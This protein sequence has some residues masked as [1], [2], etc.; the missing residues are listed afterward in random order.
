MPKKDFGLFGK[1]KNYMLV[2]EKND[3]KGDKKM[4]KQF[5]TETKILMAIAYLTCS[6]LTLWMVKDKFSETLKIKA[7]ELIFN[8]NENN[9]IDITNMARNILDEINLYYAG[10]I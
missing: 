8:K 2:W 9:I 1:S 10:K 7:Q 5:E 4:R 3:Q 6:H